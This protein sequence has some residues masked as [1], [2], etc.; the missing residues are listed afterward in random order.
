MSE[1]LPKV[2]VA[3]QDRILLHLAEHIAQNDR[4]VVGFEMTRPGIAEAC[5]QHPPNVSRTMRSLIRDEKVT[6]HTRTIR[7]ED[8]RQ[9][10]WQ[11]TQQGMDAAQ[12]L[13]ESLGTTKVLLRNQDG[14]LLEVEA[15]EAPSRLSADISLLQVL[16]HAQH[17]GVLTYGDIRFGVISK[18]EDRLPKPGRLTPMTGAHATYHNKPPVTRPV[19]GRVDELQNL[20]DWLI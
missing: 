3:V 14:E 6:E 9:K 10:T 1:G 19:H 20:H 16:L 11:L 2:S 8:R 13:S 12:K 17:E 4:Y 15:S 18:N 5:A 7:G